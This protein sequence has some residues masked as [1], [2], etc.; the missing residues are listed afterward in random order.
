MKSLIGAV[1][2]G[3]ASL[4]LVLIT[5]RMWYRFSQGVIACGRAFAPDRITIG[6][7]EFGPIQFALV[8]GPL[9]ALVG[10]IIGMLVPVV[11]CKWTGSGKK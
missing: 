10:G 4:C 1:I 11:Y 6:G 7:I 5:A 2:G 9:A 3:S 8:G